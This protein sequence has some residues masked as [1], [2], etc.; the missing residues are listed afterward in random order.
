MNSEADSSFSVSTWSISKTVNNSVWAHSCWSCNNDSECDSKLRY[1][2]LCSCL[3]HSASYY[4][5]ISINM[6]RHLQQHHKI[7]VES[8]VDSVQEATLEQLEQLEQ[9]YLNTKSSDQIKEIDA[10]V[11]EK[12][13]NQNTINKTLI[14]LIVVWNLLFQMIEW[15]EFHTF[16]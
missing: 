16:C 12:Q 4:T 3:R 8:S 13:L 11:F 9:L 6:W 1:Y 15:S 2:T 14:F 10:Q 7:T 5:S